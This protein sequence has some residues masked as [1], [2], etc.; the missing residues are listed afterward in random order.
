MFCISGYANSPSNTAIDTIPLHS[1]RLDVNSRKTT[2]DDIVTPRVNQSMQES[3]RNSQG[4]TCT[5]GSLSQDL[6]CLCSE[7][8]VL[9]ASKRPNCSG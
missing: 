9:C 3:I 2:A 4:E 5:R 7:Y 1:V 6:T 8:H